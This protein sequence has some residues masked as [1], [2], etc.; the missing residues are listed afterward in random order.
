[1]VESFF[2]DITDKRIRRGVFISVADLEAAIKEYIA[3][4]NAKPKLLIW[5]AKASDILSLRSFTLVLL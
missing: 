3:A 5:I 4:Y 2:H 1:M